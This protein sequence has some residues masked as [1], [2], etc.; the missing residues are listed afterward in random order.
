VIA[1]DMELGS[2]DTV[3]MRHKRAIKKLINKIGGFKPWSD[4]DLPDKNSDEVKEVDN[5]SEPEKEL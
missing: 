5:Q 1:E 4:S 2:E 3:R